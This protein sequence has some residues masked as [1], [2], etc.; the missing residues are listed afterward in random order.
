MSRPALE[1]VERAPAVAATSEEPEPRMDGAG[2]VI[3]VDGSGRYVLPHPESGDPAKWLRVTEFIAA[4]DD[5]SALHQWE[6]RSLFRA[7]AERPEMLRL[8]RPAGDGPKWAQSAADNDLVGD[9]L[10][11]AHQSAAT[12]TSLHSLMEVFD[13]DG[14]EPE[15]E[16]RRPFVL[17]YAGALRR[18][19]LSSVPD[20]IE[21]VVV[22]LEHP[23]GRRKGLAG[24]VDRW[25]MACQPLDLPDGS[26]VEPGQLVVADIKTGKRP[27][28]DKFRGRQERP[29]VGGV[30]A[31]R[32]D[33][34]RR[35]LRGPPPSSNAEWGIVVH[36]PA[37]AD[38]P[39]CALWWGAV[40]GC[41]RRAGAVPGRPR[42]PPGHP[43]TAPV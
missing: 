40:G 24:T 35:R 30:S 21:R 9:L 41:T 43:S 10:G 38:P 20:R 13:R 12:G 28:D 1:P 32:L 29:A 17:A 39:S 26:R 36:A 11:G 15:D 42:C 7:C 27:P 4:I 19:G 37:E 23:V 2:N 34:G 6:L 25:L 22:N 3:E 16:S 31:S 8:A 33:V 14:T 18:A 5:T